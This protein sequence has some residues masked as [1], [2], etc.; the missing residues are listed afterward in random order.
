VT[1]RFGI[2]FLPEEGTALAAF[3][4]WWSQGADGLI[5]PALL[6]APRRYG[7]H[8]TLKAPMHLAAGTTVDGLAAAITAF[9]ATRRQALGPPL[10]VKALNDFIALRP[11]APCGALDRLAA[12]CVTAFDPFRAPLTAAELERR[13]GLP[14]T[15]QQGR[16]LDRWGYPYVFDQFRFHMTLTDRVADPAQR[17]ALAAALRPRAAAVAAAPLIVGSLCLMMQATDAAPFLPLRRI[18]LAA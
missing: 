17:R 5:D 6:A 15:G 13:R 7:F 10:V 1:A 11:A 3:G 9:A 4:Q 18:P 12:D 8:A 14:L 2:Y 16:L